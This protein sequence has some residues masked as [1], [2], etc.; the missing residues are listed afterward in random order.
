MHSSSAWRHVERSDDLDLRVGRDPVIPL[1]AK[2]MPSDGLESVPRSPE[3]AESVIDSPTVARHV[4]YQ[5]ADILA[6]SLKPVPY[7]GA[8]FRRPL[9]DRDAALGVRP[10]IG[11]RGTF[12]ASATLR[13]YDPNPRPVD[14]AARRR[15]EPECHLVGWRDELSANEHG[16]GW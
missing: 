13:V 16:S 5:L 14:L 8:T 9:Y 11:L 3:G 2:D 6:A 10:V 1:D 15:V 12:T 7:E 4:A